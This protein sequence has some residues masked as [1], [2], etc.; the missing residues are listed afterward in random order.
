MGANFESAFASQPHKAS[1]RIVLAELGS[2]TMEFTRLAQITKDPKYFDAVQRITDELERSQ[3]NTRLPG[4]WPT[5]IDASGCKTQEL[6]LP[7]GSS[8]EQEVIAGPPTNREDEVR[9]GQKLSENLADEVG[10][11]DVNGLP[12]NH[13]EIGQDSPPTQKQEPLAK[14]PPVML[15]PLADPSGKS[16]IG[17]R[18]ALDLQN[19]PGKVEGDASD[20]K[21]HPRSGKRHAEVAKQC[22]PQG[23]KSPP[24]AAV[25]T[26]TL[27][28][29]ADSL[30]EYF[31]KASFYNRSHC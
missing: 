9:E 1:T 13:S 31:P 6:Y 24:Y 12:K 19:S 27:G 15:E 2:L 10:A 3:D 4:M 21:D 30:Y 16:G 23:L 28:G 11:K 26:F 8:T 14:P 22:M 29:M 17:D 5:F 7:S 25:D 18:E 20:V